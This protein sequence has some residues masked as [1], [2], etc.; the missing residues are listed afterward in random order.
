MDLNRIREE[1]L[2][3]RAGFKTLLMTTISRQGVPDSSYAECLRY[4]DDYY[5]FASAH[6]PLGQNLI[7]SGK[8]SLL[9][10]EA[11]NRDVGN[12]TGKRI[13][14]KS[15]ANRIASNSSDFD[16]IVQLFHRR[17]DDVSPM[18]DATAEFLLFRLTPVT[19]SYVHGH[20]QAYLLEGRDL[21]RVTRLG[22]CHAVLQ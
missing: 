7:D 10:I 18:L 2:L 1:Y 20:A 17:G 6:E 9:F 16:K 15:I 13:I 14:L 11:G 4:Q 21:S 8:V 3:F 12:S 22:C 19:G 5:V